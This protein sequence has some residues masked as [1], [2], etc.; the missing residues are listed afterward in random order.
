[1]DRQ[2]YRGLDHL[3]EHLNNARS[4]KTLD[5]AMPDI[6]LAQGIAMKQLQEEK[7]RKRKEDAD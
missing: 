7:L 2:I 1:M 6:L 4:S 5:E 3:I